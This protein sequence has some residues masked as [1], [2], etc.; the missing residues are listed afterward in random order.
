VVDDAMRRCHERLRREGIDLS[1]YNT[2][3]NAADVADIRRALGIDRWNIQSISYGTTLAQE[4]LRSYPDGV[5]SVLLDS[6]YP[7]DAHAPD[8]TASSAAHGMDTLAT[9][10]AASPA[11]LRA[12]PD[13][14]AEISEVIADYDAQPL[15]LDIADRAGATRHL[16]IDGGDI[17]A[18]LFN[19]MYDTQ[20]LPVL[21]LG[22][23]QIGQR[24]TALIST[25]AKEA[26]GQLFDVSEGMYHAVECQDRYSTTSRE[27]A[28]EVVARDPR[29]TLLYVVTPPAY[30]KTWGAAPTPDFTHPMTWDG[31]VL[32]LAGAY[33]PV[34]PPD[35]SE[36]VA[37]WFPRSTFLLFDGTGH[38]VFRTNDCANA[39]VVAFFDN[40][41]QPLDRSC[42][43]T[44]GPPQWA[45][46]PP[47]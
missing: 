37:G 16:V 7:V 11:C 41:D 17:Y 5:R 47:P 10:C 19:A 20:L 6:V 45:A 13:L 39:L 14:A 23:G 12:H 33:D 35:W 1:Q 9:G 40:P 8:I 43:A 36:R 28:E 4:V 44:I 26:F 2:A 21:P 30:C 24:D 46:A 18:G 22:I 29:A 25:L 15:T 27:A 34:T 32:V 3:T 31:P 38:G 42:V